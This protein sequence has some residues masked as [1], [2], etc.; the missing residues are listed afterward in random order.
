MRFFTVSTTLTGERKIIGAGFQF[1]DGTTVAI[2]ALSTQGTLVCK[3]ADLE[4]AMQVLS[5]FKV[6]LEWSE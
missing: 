3:A 5:P 6:S 2:G 1:P 4:E